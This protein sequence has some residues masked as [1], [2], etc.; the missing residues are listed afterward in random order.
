M[1][2][3]LFDI[4]VSIDKTTSLKAKID[5]NAVLSGVMNQNLSEHISFTLCSEVYIT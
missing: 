5:S 2:L 1:Y 3:L 4:N